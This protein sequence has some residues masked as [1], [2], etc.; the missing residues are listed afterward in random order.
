MQDH[1]GHEDQIS[2]FPDLLNLILTNRI[3][4][5]TV[6]LSKG[7]WNRLYFAETSVLK[8]NQEKKR[9]SYFRSPK[10]DG[11]STTEANENSEI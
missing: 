4:K 3:D 7:L 2:A 5:T 8:E 1:S 11:D 9:T 10:T 6:N